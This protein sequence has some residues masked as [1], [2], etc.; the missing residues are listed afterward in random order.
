MKR[1]LIT[2]ITG[3]DGS[4]LAELLLSKGYEVHGIIRRSS[5]F[6]T[7]RIDHLYK[8]VHSNNNKMILH[9]SDLSDAVSLIKLLYSIR[10]DEI[11][12]LGAQS[13]V[14]VSFDV[15]EYT[16]DITGLGTLR[17][18]EAIRESGLLE[19]IRFYQASSSEMYGKVLETPQKETTPFYPRSPYAC[20]KVFA[21]YLTVNYRE[22]YNLHA[23]NGILFN[24]ESPRR[25]ET[26]VT[27]KITHAAAR[28]KLGIQDKLFLGNL[29]A[30]RDWGHAQDYVEAMWLMLQ[31]DNPDDYV[32]ATGETHSVR[33]FCQEAFQLLD[34]DWEKYV[35]YDPRYERPT[36]VDLLLGDPSKA[37]KI[38]GWE[39]KTS[40]KEL[41]RL[42]IE[43]DLTLAKREQAAQSV[44]A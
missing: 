6:N 42:M 26:F 29:D 31:Q 7:N 3:Q 25:G 34:L 17:L 44:I 23:S 32:I 20:A 40:F 14:R 11:Y 13:H 28:I 35:D 16:G 36:E 12:N 33:E 39:P 41:V 1:A 10:P 15:P 22:S 8:D 9:Y 21:H 5:S 24:H 30:K 37:K 19:H 38:L 18:L 2:G 43:A 4:Y 27:R